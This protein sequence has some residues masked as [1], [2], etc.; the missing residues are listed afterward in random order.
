MKLSIIIVAYHNE[1]TI[2]PC[3]ASIR[4]RTTVPFE[5]IVVD[6][7]NDSLTA[8]QV[9]A[10]QAGYPTGQVRLLET[11]ENIGFARGCNEGARSAQGDFL[12]FL[13]PDTVLVNDA[14]RLLTDFMESHR[15]ALIVGPMVLDECG[16]VTRTCRNLPT[17][18]RVFMDATG[19]DSLTGG[20]KLLR[21]PHTEARAVG[22][23]IGA[24][25]VIGHG[26][27]DFFNGFDERFFIFF[28]EVDLC[29]RA[30]DAGG[31]VWFYPEAKVVHLGGVSCESRRNR[32]KAIVDFRKSRSLYFEK[33]YGR[34]QKR[35]LASISRLECLAKCAVFGAL[36]LVEGGW[37]SG[38]K[39][40][41]YWRAAARTKY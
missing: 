11:G 36:S 3:L 16:Q 29:K 1:D 25:L 28:E 14:G 8:R 9:K 7:S 34:R 23:I 31:E 15:R 13:N 17:L 30:L 21:F 26:S 39:A 2:V 38:E 32:A 20:Y 40:K 35:L 10:F 18:F 37:V 19:L 22:Q 27:F 4:D 6:N 24:C 33:H 5:T 41:G 12:M